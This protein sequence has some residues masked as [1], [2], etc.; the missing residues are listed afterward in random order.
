MSSGKQPIVTISSL[1]S[2][3]SF[4][5]SK[6]RHAPTVSGLRTAEAEITTS[7]DGSITVYA[8][9]YAVCEASAGTVVIDL[10]KCRNGYTQPYQSSDAGIYE[11]FFLDPETTDWYWIVMAHAEDQAERNVCH[12]K[13][14]RLGTGI[15]IDDQE[16]DA[17]ESLTI[18]KQDQPD[19]V[20]ERKDLIHEALE[21]LTDRQKEIV[22]LFYIEGK[23]QPEIARQLGISQPAVH[24]AL[25]A[26]KHAWEKNLRAL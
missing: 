4:S 21:M 14:D 19:E 16:S 13:A 8:S 22:L 9:G 26:A 3:L 25:N 15:S 18:Q 24:Y 1:L 23:S 10:R 6:N 11:S 5:E 20:L 7:P 17:W 2:R 12:R